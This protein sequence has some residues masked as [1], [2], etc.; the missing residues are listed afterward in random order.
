[1]LTIMKRFFWVFF[2]LFGC[3]FT[4]RTHLFAFSNWCIW[5]KLYIEITRFSCIVVL[6]YVLNFLSFGSCE[7]YFCVIVVVTNIRSFAVITPSFSGGLVTE[8]LS[9]FEACGFLIVL[10]QRIGRFVLLLFLLVHLKA[11]DKS[12]ETAIVAVSLCIALETFSQ[13]LMILSTPKMFRNDNDNS[14]LYRLIQK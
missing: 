1:M 2:E 11:C 14:D 3:F 5:S 8:F 6:F 4:S 10:V 12:C 13:L 9:F 7:I